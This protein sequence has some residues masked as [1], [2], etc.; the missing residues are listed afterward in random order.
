MYFTIFSLT[1]AIL[2]TSIFIWLIT[3]LRKR[4]FTLKY[5][6]IYPLLALLLLCMARITLPAEL[7]FTIVIDSTVFLPAIQTFFRK[8]IFTFGQINVN[9]N[10]ISAF[11]WITGAIII[12]LRR[13]RDYLHFKRLLNLLPATSD[14]HLY[15]ICEQLYAPEN[16]K[17]IV[18]T[19]I[20][21]PAVFGFRNPV[22]LLPDIDFSDD[23]LIG[24]FTHELIHYK[25]KHALIK[26]YTE[27]VRACF[28]WNPL[29]KNLSFEMAHALEMHT[30][31]MVCEKI[32]NEQQKAYLMALAK[33]SDNVDISQ[34]VRNFSC[35][36]V[37]EKNEDILR[38]RFK[39]ILEY[40]YKNQKNFRLAMIPLILSVFLLSY[41]VVFQPYSEP[42]ESD[43]IGMDKIESDFY[44]VKTEDGYDLY[45]SNDQF[46]AEIVIID[47]SLENLKIY[48]SLD[49][50]DKNNEKN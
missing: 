26:Y 25:Y 48:N 27:F 4:M 37:E 17:I 47:E 1:L 49:E 33:V 12:I 10:L 7:P 41:S 15:D 20:Q 40:N 31:K 44:L 8:P 34:S 2:W 43:F 21:S 45:D 11:I 3:P 23:E 9:L 50:V 39:M 46:V 36:L 28:W 35:R 42:K 38:Q 5:F 24:I 22:M 30:D 29:F 18:H 16:I 13:I 6:S 32:N 14:E 19:S